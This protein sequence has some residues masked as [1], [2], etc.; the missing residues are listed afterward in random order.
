MLQRMMEHVYY[1]DLFTKASQA[2]TTLDELPCVAA[3]VLSAYPHTIYRMA[4]PFNPLLGETYD[5]NRRAEAGYKSFMEQV[6]AHVHVIVVLWLSQVYGYFTLSVVPY[7]GILSRE[8]TFANSV[9][10]EPFVKVFSANFEGCV[11]QDHV[12]IYIHE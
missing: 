12:Y 3:F 11:S 2:P 1:A 9:D 10:L 5:C 6:H 7:H 4:K 8:K